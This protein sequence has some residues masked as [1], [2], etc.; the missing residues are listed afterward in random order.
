MYHK[1]FSRLSLTAVAV[2]CLPLAACVDDNYDLSDID[3]TAEIKVNNL[4]VPVNLDEI[5]LSNVFDLD[6][7]SVVKDVNG[8]YA[9]LVDGE[10]KSEE[11][12]VNAVSL[13]RPTIPATSTTISLVSGSGGVEVPPLNIGEQSFTY[14]IDGF[15][16]SFTYQTA[17][18]DKSIRKL[19]KIAVDW[20][21]NIRLTVLNNGN[22]FKS[23]AFRNVS[24]KLPAGLHT[25]DYASQNGV[26]TLPDINLSA[27]H[28]TYD[29][30]IRVDEVDFTRLTSQ[31]FSFITDPNGEK[32]GTLKI[33]G[34]I[35]VESGYVLV[36]TNSN[37]TSV[38]TQT[39][40]TLAPVGSDIL[41][42]AVDGTIRYGISDF[43]IDPV[44]LN[45]LPDLLRQEG[46]NITMTNPQLYLSINNPLADYSLD[47]NSGLT[48]T[49][50]RDNGS[51]DQFSLDA[52][53]SIKIGYNA[54]IVGPYKFCLA[55]DPSAAGDFAGF[56]NATP[57][58]YHGLSNVLSG[59]GL[60][61]TIEVSF[62]DPHVG[63]GA[64]TGFAVPQTL[65]RLEGEYHFYAPLNL[66]V[67]SEIVYDEVADGWSDETLE[68][69]TIQKL[70]LNAS[71]T[72]SLPFDIVL[73]GYPVDEAGNQCK[74]IK[75]GTPVSFG[76]VTVKAGETMPMVLESTGTITRLDGV[77]YF[78]TATVTKADVTLRPDA[79]IKLTGIKAT[80]SGFYI[81]EL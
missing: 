1:S 51:R 35:G 19:S 73:S 13:A 8:I 58:L 40:L 7:G 52:G 3:T 21:I 57:V 36:V 11:L 56:E 46:T 6:E 49:A 64:V 28:M 20:T 65:Q 50:C 16:T 67:G 76:S 30:A 9:V 4:V 33:N 48:L 2:A 38:P 47:A 25:P 12:K 22:V 63:P 43:N 26:I 81:D 66:G 37:V 41:V 24:L 14:E 45:D 70:K 27:G 71:V 74:D 17:T 79:T 54:G 53:Q 69:V 60:P 75:T 78:A 59:N 18:V 68:K 77:R 31:E 23:V 61:S 5:T 80:V 10:F 42:K 62:D 44:R 72:N 15:N 39:S 55:P 29:V 34:N 32:P